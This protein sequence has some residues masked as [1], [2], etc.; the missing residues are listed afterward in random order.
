M[1][2]FRKYYVKFFF[3]QWGIGVCT[4][5]LEDIIRQ[6]KNVFDFNWIEIKD[7]FISYADPFILKTDDGNF[8][9]LFETFTS[10]MQ[11]GKIALQVLDSELKLISEKLLLSE[12][13][14]VSYPFYFKENGKTYVFP[15]AGESNSLFCYE[16]DVLNHLL[17]NKIKILDL[18]VIDPTILKYE[19]KYWLF[20]TL[21][22]KYRHSQLHIFYADHLTGPYKS[23]SQNPVKSS[24]QGTRP[25]GAFINVDNEIYRPSQNCS[26]YYGESLIINRILSLSETEFKE[27][28]YMKLFPQKKTKF[29]YGMHTIN[30]SDGVIVV[31]GLAGYFQP[32]SQLIKFFKEKIVKFL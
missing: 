24:L 9:L 16:Y 22:G 18:P 10:Q 6:K 19:E 4:G 27:E 13:Y 25:A 7:K 14:H 15:E 5:N 32:V 26:N 11:D 31:D 2:I 28:I 1:N 12:S 23:H 20:G 3:K 21:I 30:G 8:H 29:K 17:L